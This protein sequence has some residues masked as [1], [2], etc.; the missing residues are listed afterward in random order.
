MGVEAVYPK[1]KVLSFGVI[2][3]ELRGGVK[4]SRAVPIFGFLAVSV[5]ACVAAEHAGFGGFIVDAIK[6]RLTGP[7]V[8]PYDGVGNPVSINFCAANECP[9]VEGPVEIMS[10]VDEMR[11]YRE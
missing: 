2:F 8:G 11:V 5:G 4:K 3:E 10:T 7:V 9:G 6:E 1:E